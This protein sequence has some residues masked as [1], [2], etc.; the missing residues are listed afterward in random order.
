MLL[1]KLTE[2]QEQIL[3]QQVITGDQPGSVLRD[4]G[5]LLE[6]LGNEKVPAGGKYN[7]LPI[8]AID[9]L[10]Q[11]L[12]RPLRLKLTRPQLRSH[13]YLQ[14]L[15]LLLRA[16]GLS[17]VDGV[18]SKAQLVLD[19]EMF[20]R[21]KRLNFTEQYFTLLEAWLYFGQP[22]THGGG[23]SWRESLVMS[24][25]QTWRWMPPKGF[26]STPKKSAEQ[27]ILGMFR[28]NY[29]LALM[30]L[31]GL[32]AVDHP[33]K[34]VHPWGPTG[35]S[36]LPF[37]DA[38][39]TLLGERLNFRGEID[40]EDTGE[41]EYEDNP[42]SAPDFG[43]WQRLFQPYFPEWRENL[44]PLPIPEREGLFIFRVSLGDIWRRIAIPSTKT[45]EELAG[46]ILKSVDFDDDHL[47]EFTYR[48]RL[49]RTVQVLHPNMEEGPWTDQVLIGTLPLEPGESMKFVFDFGDNWKF[50][51][52]LES[53]EPLPKKAKAKILEQHG[54]A[55]DQYPH[56]DW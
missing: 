22:E 55:P 41:E 39:F 52:R 48:D 56:H 38:V 8:K 35:V 46:W 40:E 36:H 47:Y 30:D 10:D 20:A 54:E 26:H 43:I 2:E 6:Y 33:Q 16:T 34:P 23:S 37:G 25:L 50:D 19:P 44:V 24:A 17:R 9:I 3:H 49:N 45:L 32:V 53:I 28:N 21:W 51:V 12:T 13:P 42:L 27:S 4:F 11:R 31:F 1:M 29:Q 5:M 14:G 7:L 15:Q 18:G